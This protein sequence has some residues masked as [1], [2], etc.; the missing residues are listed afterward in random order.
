MNEPAAGTPP[1]VKSKAVIIQRGL[2]DIK[3]AAIGPQYDDVLR[4]KI[5]D[6][7]KLPFALPDLFFRLLCCAEVRHGTHIFEVARRR[8]QRA[9]QQVDV[10]DSTIRHQQT[11]FNIKIRLFVGCVVDSL[12]DE[13]SVAGMTSLQY[14]LQRWLNRSIVFKDV[15]DFLR[16]VDLST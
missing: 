8:F 5:H 11:M 14:P 4:R 7:S 15:V 13:I 1:F 6:L 10:L 3:A 9:S 2:V 12:L 16:P